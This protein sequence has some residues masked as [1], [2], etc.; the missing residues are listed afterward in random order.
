[1]GNDNFNEFFTIQ[2]VMTSNVE[3]ECSLVALKIC[4]WNYIP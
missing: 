3:I 1:M 4:K 2:S